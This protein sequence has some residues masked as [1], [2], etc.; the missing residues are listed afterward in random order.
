MPKDK[1]KNNFEDSIGRLEKLVDNMESGESSLEQNLAWFE[2]GME[3]IKICQ[4]HLTDAE[5]RVQELIKNNDQIPE[6]KDAK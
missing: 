1:V 3:L 5:H 2:E 6:D 4:G